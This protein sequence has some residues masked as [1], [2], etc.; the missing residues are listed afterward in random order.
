MKFLPWIGGLALI[1]ALGF[2]TDRPEP[3]PRPSFIPPEVEALPPD[4]VSPPPDVSPWEEL[5]ES[6]KRSRTSPCRMPARGDIR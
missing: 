4:P 6:V 1:L 5:A 2:R 3:E